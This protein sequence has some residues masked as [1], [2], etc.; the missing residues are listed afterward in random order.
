MKNY[1]FI[2]PVITEDNWVLGGALTASQKLVINP[3]RNWIPWVPKGET[4]IRKIETFSCTQFATENAIEIIEKK[5]FNRIANYSERALA[6]AS[7]NSQ[8]GNDPHK[9]AEIIRKGGLANEASLPFTDTIASWD[10]FMS[11]RPLTIDIIEEGL[12]WLERYNFYHEWVFTNGTLK[13]KQNKLWEALLY[14]PLGV[15]VDAWKFDGEKY[16]KNEGDRDNHWT[17]LVDASWGKSWT[18]YDSYLDD[19][20]Y[21]KYLDWNYD[22]GFSKLYVLNKIPKRGFFGSIRD[23]FDFLFE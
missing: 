6:I 9:V 12:L 7:G 23:Y 18:I 1:G 16:V 4:Q 5:Q 20:D 11:P 10:D 22:F 21:I 13:E 19:Q 17:L 14:S 8:F 15:S 3:S 2:E